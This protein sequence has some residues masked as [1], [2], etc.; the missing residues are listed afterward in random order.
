LA[1]ADLKIIFHKQFADKQ[2]FITYLRP[3]FH[4][5][6]YNRYQTQYSSTHPDAGYPDWLG[7]SRKF[8]MNSTNLSF[9]AI[10]VYQI[11]Y[12]T[13]LWLPELQIRRGRKV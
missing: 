5:P 10:T 1:I 11:K 8:V 12:S 4:I 7:P 3:T 6:T 2:L 13:V 9:L